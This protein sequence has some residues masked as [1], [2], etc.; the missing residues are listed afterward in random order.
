MMTHESR[1]DLIV[2]AVPSPEWAAAAVDYGRANDVPVVL[3]VR[4]LWPDV[5][6]NAVPRFA[7]RAGELA[8]QPYRRLTQRICRDA[9]ALV[10]VSQGYLDWALRQA[11]RGRGSQDGVVPI[12]FE[13]EKV[14]PEI[15]A[16][17]RR[18]LHEQG[19]DLSSTTCFFSGSLERSYDLKTLLLAA[20]RLRSRGYGQL[21]FVICGDGSSRQALEQ[22][23]RRLN[24]TNV[25]FLVGSTRQCC[26][27][28]L[29][30]PKSAFAL[31]RRCH[32]RI[33]Q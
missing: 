26:R 3:D 9:D 16:E 5:F 10:G 31:R 30:S 2:A 14:A 6:L 7:R 11:D 4:D 21:Q 27:W 33:T 25:F 13:P 24:L 28:S 20:E 15:L 8:V 17:H 1:P 23:A 32:S 22:H 18:Q 29:Q 19:I 12:G